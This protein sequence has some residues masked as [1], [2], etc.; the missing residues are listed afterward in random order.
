MNIRFNFC[1]IL[2]INSPKSYTP[3]LQNQK[4]KAGWSNKMLIKQ[5]IKNDL[6]KP[7]CVFDWL[8]NNGA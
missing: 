8:L 6:L 5:V 3:D 1:Y 2:T 7:V 4:S